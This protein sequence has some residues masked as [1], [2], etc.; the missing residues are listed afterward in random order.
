MKKQRESFFI[1][2]T[3]E[4]EILQ[5]VLSV[6]TL[7]LVIIGIPYGLYCFWKMFIASFGIMMGFKSEVGLFRACLILF[8]TDI[9]T[10]DGQEAMKIFG[11]YFYR[12]IGVVI[13]IFVFA[14]LSDIPI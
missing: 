12:F 5:L 14:M 4:M 6:V 1:I 3:I 10:Q 7:I 9:L 2:Q 11:K 13:G 8:R